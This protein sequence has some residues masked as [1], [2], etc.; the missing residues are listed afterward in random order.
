MKRNRND[1]KLTQEDRKRL[2]TIIKAAKS[3]KFDRL[4][5]QVLLLTDIGEHGPKLQCADAAAQLGLSQ[6]S[7]GRIKEAYAKNNSIQDVF[8]FAGLSYQSNLTSEN[9]PSNDRQKKKNIQYIEIDNKE[10]GDFLVEHVKC[11]VTLSKEERETLKT[12]IRQGKHSH[13]KFNRAKILLLADEGPEGPAKTDEEIAN[14]LGV[15]TPTVS[16]VR[17]LLVKEG[18]L[19]AVLSFNHTNAGRPRKIDGAVEAVLV[20]Q[21]CSKP[22]EGRCKW[23]LRLLA[24]RLV[25][26]EVVD[27]ITHG[28]I[29]N[30]L[31]KTNLSLGNEKNG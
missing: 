4:K 12:I 20:A 13:R 6:R 23:T 26:L 31:K 15:S 19:E 1:V 14:E 27:S 11:R 5:A 25:E 2:D 3:S 21:A 22:P 7:V 17:R 9:K 29:A 8:L 24:D 30:A 18:S 16:R 28:S 10:A